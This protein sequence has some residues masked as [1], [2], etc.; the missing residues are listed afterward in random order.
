MVSRHV[1]TRGASDATVSESVDTL[2]RTCSPK[3]QD[4]ER[5]LYALKGPTNC[6]SPPSVSRLLPGCLDLSRTSWR[7]LSVS[8]TVFRQG[9][10]P[11]EIIL[12]FTAK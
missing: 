10:A 5:L 9:G 7:G 1:I 2:R 11:C 6:E 8:V 4:N 3:S 12:S